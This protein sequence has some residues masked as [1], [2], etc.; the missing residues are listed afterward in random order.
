M[1]TIFTLLLVASSM[2]VLAQDDFSIEPPSKDTA[3][4]Q[5]RVKNEDSPNPWNGLYIGPVASVNRG[6][7]SNSGFGNIINDFSFDIGGE[8]CYMVFPNIGFSTGLRFQQFSFSYSYS[9]VYS[10]G[11]VNGTNTAYRTGSSDTTVVAGY[12][13]TANYS[14]D[15]LRV[16]LL[17]RYISSGENKLGFYF[18]LGFVAD[19]L[20]NAKVSGT[21]TQ[22]QYNLSQS[23]NTAWYDYSSSLPANNANINET[24]LDASR[25]NLSFRAALGIMI[26]VKSFFIV[27]D[28]GI[29]YRLLNG[30]TG[31]N[32]VVSFGNA[33]YYF[34]GSGNYGCFNFQSLEAKFIFKL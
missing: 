34:Y 10:T 5:K 21:A 14:F 1:K 2:L 30:G 29:D 33:Q 12:N 23:P 4:D 18:E 31:T 20:V 22:T 9:N 3:K 25:F 24:N 8:I 26:P 17:A 6:V 11:S 32:D 27:V 13:S 19:V 28:Y 7:I 16:P 15:Y